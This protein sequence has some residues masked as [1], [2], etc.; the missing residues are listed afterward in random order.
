MQNGPGILSGMPGPSGLEVAAIPPGVQPSAMCRRFY[1]TGAP[2]PSLQNENVAPPKKRAS[3]VEPNVLP[4][5]VS[6]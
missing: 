6:T 3:D 1:V 5:S 2:L 4:I